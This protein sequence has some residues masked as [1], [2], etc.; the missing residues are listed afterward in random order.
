MNAARLNAR[1]LIPTLVTSPRLETVDG[2][3][4]TIRLP[5]GASRNNPLTTAFGPAVRVTRKYTRPLMFHT[6]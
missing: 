1:S 5:Y 3:L 2:V 4:S 6:K